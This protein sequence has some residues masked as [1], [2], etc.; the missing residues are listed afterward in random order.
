MLP[1]FLAPAMSRASSGVWRK[2]TPLIL[3]F[4]LSSG[5]EAK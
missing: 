1:S 4:L 2:D 5:I 3:R